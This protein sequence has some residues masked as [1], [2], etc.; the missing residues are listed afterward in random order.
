M[1]NTRRYKIP[2]TL[3]LPKTFPHRLFDYEPSN[4]FFYKKKFC[5]NLWITIEFYERGWNNEMVTTLAAISLSSFTLR[6]IDTRN[7]NPSFHW[8]GRSQ[9]LW[10]PLLFRLNFKRQ[11]AHETAKQ[12]TWL[13]LNGQFFSFI[14]IPSL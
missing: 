14:F 13:V 1:I 5:R 7:K 11:K 12:I 6:I 3:I 10:W 9:F 8:R 2:I 4:H